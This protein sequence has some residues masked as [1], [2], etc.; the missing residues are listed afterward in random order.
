VA[1]LRRGLNIVVKSSI[2]PRQGRVVRMGL[3]AWS[4]PFVHI[5]TDDVGGVGSQRHHYYLC[6][7]P[8][9]ALCSLGFGV[10][11]R[12]GGPMDGLH[13]QT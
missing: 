12:V 9:P 1:S 3:V 7:T 6:D 8:T 2:L 5:M 13:T 4:P 10:A 11:R